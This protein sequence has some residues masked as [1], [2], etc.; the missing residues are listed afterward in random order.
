MDALARVLRRRSPAPYAL[1]GAAAVA[2]VGLAAFGALRTAH[3]DTAPTCSDAPAA[4]AGVWDDAVRGDLARRF[5]RAGGDATFATLAPR[6]DDYAHAWVAERTDACRATHVRGE[7]SQARLDERNACLDTRL[8]EFATRVATLGEVTAANLASTPGLIDQLVAPAACSSRAALAH[9]SAPA[10]AG[11]VSTFD[12]GTLAAQFGLGWSVSTDGI[13][14]GRSRAE[15]RPADGAMR[16]TGTVEQAAS[17][18]AWAGA[19]FYPGKSP[20]APVATRAVT[21]PVEAA[22]KRDRNERLS[23]PSAS[24]ARTAASVPSRGVR[25]SSAVRR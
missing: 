3:G 10:P 20:M 13:M 14:G 1:A 24:S 23:R 11:L 18:I 22:S 15:L 9:E 12:D 2:C 25:I 5:A 17:P 19:M 8:R 4:L 6:V 21:S 7:Q 16:V